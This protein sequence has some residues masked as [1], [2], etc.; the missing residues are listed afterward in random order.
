MCELE[1]SPRPMGHFQ[2]HSADQTQI[3]AKVEAD[4]EVEVDAVAGL[5]V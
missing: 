2:L 4:S 5:Q 3:E 1:L